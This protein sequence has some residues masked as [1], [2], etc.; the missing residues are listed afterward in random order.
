MLTQHRQNMIID[1]KSVFV[2]IMVMVIVVTAI[3]IP[4][5]YCVTYTGSN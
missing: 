4:S 3:C 2:K 5:D 1:R